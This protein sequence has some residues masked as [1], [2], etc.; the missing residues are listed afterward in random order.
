M[1]YEV[2]ASR[3]PGG[4]CMAFDR[5]N[6]VCQ[7]GQRDATEGHHWAMSSRQT[8]L[9]ALPHE[10]ADTGVPAKF[11]DGQMFKLES[12]LSPLS[13]HSAA[14]IDPLSFEKQQLTRK[15]TNRTMP[16]TGSCSKHRQPLARRQRTALS[17]LRSFEPGCAKAEAR[18]AGA[19][20][21]M[22]HGFLYDK[23]WQDLRGCPS[24]LTPPCTQP[25]LAHARNVRPGQFEIAVSELVTTQHLAGPSERR[26]ASET[27]PEP[28]GASNSRQV[29]ASH[30][31][32]A[33][34]GGVWPGMRARQGPPAQA[35]PGMARLGTAGRGGARQ[36]R[37]LRRGRVARPGWA[38]NPYAP[39]PRGARRKVQACCGLAWRC[40]AWCQGSWRPGRARQPLT[41]TSPCVPAVT[42]N[43]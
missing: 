29:R 35:R 43:P 32:A 3:S 10:V 34:R 25:H 6:G 41:S 9:V 31:V 11:K 5:S 2:R 39:W 36:G 20:R 8:D 37:E 42:Y 23:R 16:T 4:S 30:G 12:K 19:R 24:R 18:P 26:I 13:M 21:L 14:G 1:Q 28:S 27:G 15:C 38:Q 7:L 22:W 17:A 33:R 40:T